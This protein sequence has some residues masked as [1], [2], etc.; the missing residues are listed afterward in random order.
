MYKRK[1]VFTALILTMMLTSCIKRYDPVIKRSDEGKYVITGGVNT[2][3]TIQHINVSIA[4]LLT[5]KPKVLTVSFC[6]VK[7]IDGK[8]NSYP[9]KDVFDGNYE[10]II[11]QSELLPGSTFKVD[12][13]VPDGTHIVSDFDQIQDC[14][15]V[16][17]V[18]YLLDEIPTSNPHFPIR[19]IQ[20]YLDMNG[21]N[22]SCR[23]FRFELNETWKF[24]ANFA[25]SDHDTCWLT[26]NIRSIFTL[27]TKDQTKNMYKLMPLHFVDNY[28]SQRLRYKY[29]LLINQ[30]SLSE[31]AFDYWD[32]M[33]KNNVE[34]G[35]LYENQPFQV[36][37]NLHN[38]SDPTKQ[39][40]GFFGASTRKSKRIFVGDIKGLP[41]E[42]LDCQPVVWP[43]ILNP[44]CEDCTKKVGGTNVKPSFW[45]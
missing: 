24:S 10:A 30:F 7:I 26:S 14:P 20:F 9:A 23:N 13:Q 32:K 4:S 38:L 28:S 16:D 29:S 39:V 1:L 42:Y 22:Y 45:P 40:L 34:Q 33:R 15:E 17:S 19:G 41:I 2:G 3:D 27:S 8:G 18:Y 11:P 21:E 44:E 31:A 5:Y 6:K 36:S 37:G 25:D 12:I 35:G 43:E